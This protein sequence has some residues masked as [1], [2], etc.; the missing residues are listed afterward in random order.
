MGYGA[1]AQIQL[2]GQKHKRQKIVR[3]VRKE[4]PKGGYVH[5]QTK[6]TGHKVVR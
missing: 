5:T 1:A 2:L 6:G 3:T 4:G